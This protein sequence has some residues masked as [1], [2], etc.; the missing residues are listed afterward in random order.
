MIRP[1][2]RWIM[3][4][5]TAFVQMNG[6]DTR[7]SPTHRHYGFPRR[8]ADSRFDKLAPV[9][10]YRGA[11]IHFSVMVVSVH[12]CIAS[13]AFARSPFWRLARPAP[14]DGNVGYHTMVHRPLTAR[15]PRR[16]LEG[17]TGRDEVRGRIPF[18]ELPH[19]F[20][21]DSGYVSHANAG[22]SHPQC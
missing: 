14:S 17:W 18:D 12:N 6:P 11:A 1:Q 9:P 2:P 3:C 13:F 7:V 16:A 8:W 21:P 19:L 4:G 22:I 20:N 5:A 15:S 10:I